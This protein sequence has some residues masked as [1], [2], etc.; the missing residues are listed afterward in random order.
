MRLQKAIDKAVPHWR[1]L[2]SGEDMENTA[3]RILKEV[4]NVSIKKLD[5]RAMDRKHW[6]H[7]APATREKRAVILGK[8]VR[9]MIEDGV[10]GIV[11]PI[12]PSIRVNNANPEYLSAVEVESVRMAMDSETLRDFVLWQFH[13]G[14]RPSET[15]SVLWSDIRDGSVIVRKTKNGKPRRIPLSSAVKRMLKSRPHDCERVFFDLPSDSTLKRRWQDAVRSG[16]GR[17][18]TH[19]L[20]LYVLRHSY[21]SVL[22]QSGV[23]IEVISTLLG[24]SDLK[25]TTRY[26]KLN[27]ASLRGAV[28]LVFD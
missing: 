21:A 7:L 28:E 13:T 6:Q 3:R 14:M 17:D 20:S 4:G 26:A 10:A 27:H 5:V 1:Q 11:P 15:K 23:R 2:R 9:L 22:V 25:T 18:G 16:L 12:M 19:N 24:H 8:V